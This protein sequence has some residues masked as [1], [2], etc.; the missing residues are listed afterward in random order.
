MGREK[1]QIYNSV[2]VYYYYQG[3]SIYLT[4]LNS[5]NYFWFIEALEPNYEKVQYFKY[6]L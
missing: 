6:K 2:P 5:T 4:P 1:N 3:T